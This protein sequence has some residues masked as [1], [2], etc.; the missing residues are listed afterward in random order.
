MGFIDIHVHGLD[1]TDLSLFR[2]DFSKGADESSETDEAGIAPAPVETEGESPV[3]GDDAASSG[4]TPKLAALGF[5][6]VLGFLVATGLLVK[7]TLGGSEDAP[8][9]ERDELE[10]IDA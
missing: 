10:D 1:E 8:V 2:W 6:V 3:T 5:V 9:D 7:R 4:G